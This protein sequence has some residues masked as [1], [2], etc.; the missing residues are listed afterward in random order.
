MSANAGTLDNFGFKIRHATMRVLGK[1]V[2]IETEEVS[3]Q[4]SVVDTV[5][6]QADPWDEIIG[7]YDNDPSWQEFSS[8]LVEH[9]HNQQS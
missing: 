4:S 3:A 2:S 6:I 5:T 8:W 9:R 1:V 7:R